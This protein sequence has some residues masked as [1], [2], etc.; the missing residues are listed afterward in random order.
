MRS[1]DITHFPPKCPREEK[2]EERLRPYHV[3]NTPSRP[4]W[5]VKQRWAD[6][7]LDENKTGP[8]R[9]DCACCE[10]EEPRAR[11]RALAPSVLSR[12]RALSRTGAIPSVGARFIL[13]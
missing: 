2:R 3:E 12:S 8:N 9:Q 7:V 6:L 10:R 13:V 11:E 4:I 5:Q 1:G